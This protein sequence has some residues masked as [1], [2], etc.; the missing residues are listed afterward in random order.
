MK[1]YAPKGMDIS[2]ESVNSGYIHTFTGNILE[3]LVRE[4]TQNSL[5][6]VIETEGVL[7]LE[8]AFKEVSVSQIPNIN[9][10]KDVAIPKALR[11]WSND[12][13]AL[14]YVDLFK[15]RINSE[16]LPILKISDYNTTGLDRN[17][18]EALVLNKGTSVKRSEDSAGSY[19]IGK[20][21]PFAAS[22]LRM[23]FY[24]T[25]T[26]SSR[27]VKSMGVTNFVSFDCSDGMIA[28]GKL[29]L[30]KKGREPLEKGLNFGF[31]PR[32][33]P[34][35][36]LYIID[37]NQVDNWKENFIKTLIKNFLVSIYFGKA[38]FIIEEE[39]LTSETLNQ[40]I[41]K[42]KDDKDFVET[43]NYYSVL[44]DDNKV[45]FNLDE[46]FEKYGY[47]AEDG[48]F[49][50]STSKEANRSVLMTRLSGMKIFDRRR[51]SGSIQFNGIFR[52]EG[53]S[54]NKFLKE[55][56]NPSHDNW[57]PELSSNKSLAK[58]L[59]DD[60][61]HFFKKHV[62]EELSIPVEDE[63][64]A[65]GVSD[66]LPSIDDDKSQEDGRE[67][68]DEQIKNVKLI[69]T[70]PKVS[71]KQSPQLDGI[72]LDV[73]E[74]SLIP[75]EYG[76]GLPQNDYSKTK[77][78]DRPGSQFPG[79]NT[80]SDDSG[81]D[82]VYKRKQLKQHKEYSYKIIEKNYTNGHYQIFIFLNKNIQN[83]S[84]KINR[85]AESGLSEPVSINEF[86]ATVPSTLIGNNLLSAQVNG[87]ETVVFDLYINQ[88]SRFKMEVIGY[89]N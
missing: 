68:F 29:Y 30:G 83:L 79:G 51:I 86:K 15:R 1:W 5:D 75:G 57:N 14:Q 81:I 65:F 58:N 36:D 84:L 48:I 25:L 74:G 31:S 63:I 12:N 69:E 34:G 46:R 59:L 80:D 45:T 64:D 18:W 67:G 19:G 78:E 28:E 40:H 54:I 49:Y 9:Y 43:Y 4:V 42:F 6:A 27:D 11:T 7:R 85:I 2:K 33:E 71:T 76:G 50:L 35:T 26:Y 87:M 21:A 89:E 32:T 53:K 73:G 82:K 3:S 13:D 55:M 44:I 41:Q 20:F 52:A 77:R 39:A 60:L 23:V 17:Q 22:K 88:S 10:F 56:E 38:E 62:H 8:F 16:T 37:F 72:H 61:F 24:E 70:K 47:K 66:F